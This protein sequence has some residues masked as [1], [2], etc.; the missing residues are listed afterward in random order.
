V[1]DHIAGD[2]VL[3]GPFKGEGP[4]VVAQDD[5]D[6]GRQNPLLDVVDDGLEIGAASRNED[7]QVYDSRHEGLPKCLFMK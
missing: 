5:T 3:S 7:A 2:A 6:P 1:L 4:A